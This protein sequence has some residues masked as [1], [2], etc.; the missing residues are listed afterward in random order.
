MIFFVLAQCLMSAKHQFLQA[1][2]LTTD[3]AMSQEPW[4]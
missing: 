2:N 4:V 3:D 1:D